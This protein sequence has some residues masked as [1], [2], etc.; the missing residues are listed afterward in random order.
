MMIGV[1]L[2][3]DATNGKS[4]VWCEDQGDL[5]F[6]DEPDHLEH[7]LDV[8]DVV[9]FD[10]KVEDSLRLAMNVS[11]LLQNWGSLLNDTLTSLPDEPDGVDRDHGAT[12]I[13]M[14]SVMP[15]SARPE[16]LKDLRRHG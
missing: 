11:R 10:I 5:A 4:V 8:G 12:V 1:I 16:P 3:R 9:S 13:P 2:W 6:F 14:R 7:T 15:R